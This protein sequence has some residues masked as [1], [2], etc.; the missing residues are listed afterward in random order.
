MIIDWE[1]SCNLKSIRH[2][3]RTLMAR[4]QRS[5]ERQPRNPSS[6]KTSFKKM[7]DCGTRSLSIRASFLDSSGKSSTASMNIGQEFINGAT[8]PLR[9]SAVV[10][11]EQPVAVSVLL[12]EF[13]FFLQRLHDNRGLSRDLLCPTPVCLSR[14]KP[15]P[16]RGFAKIAD[17]GDSLFNEDSFEG[18]MPQWCSQPLYATWRFL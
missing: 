9:C 3:I 6:I 14:S 8:A 1:F 4:L 17:G 15:W 12:D 10:Y 18:D 11:V 5:P 13:F 2:C 7:I 16:E